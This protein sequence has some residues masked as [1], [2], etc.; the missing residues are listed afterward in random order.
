MSPE[1][2]NLVLP[3]FQRVLDLLNRVETGQRPDIQTERNEI[4]SEIEEAEKTAAAPSSL[5]RLEE[6]QL[7]KQAL[8]YWADEVLTEALPAWKD[9][10]LE[11]EYYG[12][13]RKRA[14]KFYF[15]GETK[16]RHATP[17]VAETWYLALALGF[18]GDIRDAFKNHLNRELP[19]N[20]DNIAEARRIWAKQLEQ[21][22]RDTV[23]ADL[24]PEPLM[25]HVAPLHG[26]TLFATA[27]VLCGLLLAA[28]GIL[29]YVYFQ[30]AP[31][32]GV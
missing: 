24:P 25:G 21:R 27:A 3:I 9:M 8:I 23:P 5:V 28:L 6:F 26:E 11:V 1:F 32:S 19:G 4:R 22:I 12:P 16:A 31:G 17:D 14:W 10:L 15:D 13:P 18:Q 29:L 20:V 30:S 2:S 7:A